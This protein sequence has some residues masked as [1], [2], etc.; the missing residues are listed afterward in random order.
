YHDS[1]ESWVELY[2]RSSHAVDL[3]GWR[4]DEGI[5]YRFAPGKILLPGGYLVIA[6][7][8]NYLRSLYPGID[9]VGPFTNMLSKTSDLITLKDAN[10]NPA[11][12]VRYFDGG[13]WPEFADGAGSSLELRDPHADN[14]IPEAWAASNEA[15]KSSWQTY[16]ARAVPQT[17]MAAP[18]KSPSAP[19]GLPVQANST[20]ACT[21]P[22][23]LGPLN[24][25]SRP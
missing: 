23:S 5:D 2:N 16:T 22:G 3:T 4:L 10:N 12:E 7:D 14:S 20:R 1:P 24:W 9:I 11:D 25:P 21:S 19:N 6:K 15:G 13:R 8:V 18:T 17:P